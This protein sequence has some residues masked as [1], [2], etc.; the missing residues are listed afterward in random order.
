MQDYRDEP[1]STFWPWAIGIAVLVLV[2]WFVS[3]LTE[4]PAQ[5]APDPQVQEQVDPAA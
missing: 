5:P 4:D 2:I 1:G 3:M